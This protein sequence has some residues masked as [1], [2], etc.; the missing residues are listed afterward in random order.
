MII[1]LLDAAINEVEIGGYVLTGF[2]LGTKPMEIFI[3]ECKREMGIP[4]REKIES[5]KNYKGYPIVT[6]KSVDAV[7][8][9]IKLKHIQR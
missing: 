7:M 6:H 1:E 8:Y 9:S 4:S 5:I 2:Q 3:K